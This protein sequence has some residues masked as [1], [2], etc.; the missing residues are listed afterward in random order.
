MV[1]ISEWVPNPEGKDADGEWVELVNEGG[2]AVV[3]DGWEIGTSGDKFSL[4]GKHLAPEEYL[5]INRSESKL[6]LRNRDE[7]LTL[8]QGGR[9]VDQ[10]SFAGSAPEG[11]AFARSGNSFRFVEPTPGKKNS[12]PEASIFDA[13]YPEGISLVGAAGTAEM[14]LLALG[15]GVLLASLTLF[16]C[17]RHESVSKLFFESN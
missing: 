4:G 8:Y 3:L 12:A 7:T 16:L 2:S 6:V 1:F 9:I 13:T 5:V 14:L 11:K 15:A 10:S 17:K